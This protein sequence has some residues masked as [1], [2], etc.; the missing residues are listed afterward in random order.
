MDVYWNSTAII[1]YRN[2]IIFVNALLWSRLFLLL[3]LRAGVALRFVAWGNLLPD[4][5]QQRSLQQIF[6]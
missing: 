4:G 5:L 3:E 6:F 2:R 1:F